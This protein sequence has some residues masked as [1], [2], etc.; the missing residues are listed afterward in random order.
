MSEIVVKPTQ[1]VLQRTLQEFFGYSAFKENQEAII[2]NLLER[3]DGLV[4]MPTGAG[5]SLCYQLPALLMRGT[6]LI[7]SPLISLMKDQVDQLNRLNIGAEFINST[8]NKAAVEQVKDKVLSEAIKLLYVAPESLAKESSIAF[9]KRITISFLAV[10][11]AHCISEWGHDFRPEYR[12]IRDT[13]VSAKKESPFIALTATATQR[14]RQDIKKN[15]RIQNATTFCTSF[16]RKNLFYEVIPKKQPD[17]LLLKVLRSHAGTTGIVY[18]MKRKKVEA[19]VHL[20]KKNNVQAVPYHAG[21]KAKERMESQDSFLSEKKNVM[22]ATIAF[23]MGIDKPDVR[24]VIHYDAPKSLEGYYQETG[25]A[26]RDGKNSIC[27]M[28]YDPNDLL[29]IEKI[30]KEK[31]KAERENGR[32]LLEEVGNYA[33][34]S[35]CRRKHL[36]FYFGE[37]FEEPCGY[38]DNCLAEQ[39]V[40]EA[41][42]H[43]EALL[44]YVKRNSLPF[45]KGIKSLSKYLGDNIQISANHEETK[46][47]ARDFWRNVLTQVSFADLL[48]K[49]ME[50]DGITLTEKGR[51]FLQA[52]Y[53]IYFKEFKQ[54]TFGAEGKNTYAPYRHQELPYH[55]PLYCLLADLREETAKAQNIPPYVVFLDQSLEEMA[56]SLPSREEDLL[57][58]TGVGRGKLEKFGKAFLDVIRDYLETHEMIS[59]ESS[60]PRQSNRTSRLKIEIIRKTDKRV[61]FE[62]IAHSLHISTEELIEEMEKICFSGVKVNINYHLDGILEQHKQAHIYDCL[63]RHTSDNLQEVV[64]A[65]NGEYT[66]EEVRLMR[67]K[68]LSEI[69]G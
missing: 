46:K 13:I 47:P 26:G 60:A 59:P 39:G 11:E 18:C 15:L 63:R 22:V 1:E 31:N 68:L 48:G 42:P 35:C 3:K 24:F 23:G 9:L 38:C 57:K 45:N 12:K 62:D 6:A 19:L 44:Q 43:V 7:I 33:E 37:S 50:I 41:T 20:L 49:D 52:P 2:R 36:L 32:F 61:H 40:F 4:I 55:E 29:T 54:D 5:K 51:S 21:M 34:S 30:Q 69:N 8:L 17:S 14:V 10:D 58:I 67:I 25:R 53:P 27:T 16:N 66:Y 65:L 56:S 64:T 28:F